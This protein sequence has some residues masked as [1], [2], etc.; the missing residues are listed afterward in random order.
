MFATNA[1]VANG[2]EVIVAPGTSPRWGG[3]APPTP[4]A[5]VANADPPPVKGLFHVWASSFT[6]P[7]A[8]PFALWNGKMQLTAAAKKALATWDP[9]RQTI[10]KGCEPKGMPTIMEQP[11]GL[12]FEDLEKTI[13]IRIE[14]YDTVRVVHMSD[15]VAVPKTKSL[16]GH[17]AGRWE[18]TTLVVTT[19][20]ISWPYIAPT[21]L[22]QGPS[23][24][25]VERFTPS[26]DS[27]RLEYTVTITDPDTFTVPAVLKRAWVWN[28][29][30]RVQK[31]GCGQRQNGR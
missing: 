19:T 5:Q 24:S 23:S 10:A 17:S 18:G 12:A 4:P 21:G 3:A 13:A 26:Q 9:V 8:G 2:K 1:L 28:P 27:T 22:P 11:Y 14:E 16:L 6:D 31:Y 15:G 30:E 7:A 29:N 20:G 25:M